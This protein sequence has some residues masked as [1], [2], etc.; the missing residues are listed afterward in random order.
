MSKYQYDLI[1]L[2]LYG[3]PTL[4]IEEVEQKAIELYHIIKTALDE[5]RE[6]K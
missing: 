3:E 2:I 4:S 5:N 1:A 6:R